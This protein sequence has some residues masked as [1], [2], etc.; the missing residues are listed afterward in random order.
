MKGMGGDCDSEGQQ[1]TGSR[2]A[3]R[4]GRVVVC[5]MLDLHIHTHIHTCTS[6]RTSVHLYITHRHK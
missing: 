4:I 3:G 2:R 1:G 6:I 5:N